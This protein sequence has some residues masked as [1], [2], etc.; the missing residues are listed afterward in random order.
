M[1]TFEK[2][3]IIGKNLEGN[4]SST[5]VHCPGCIRCL[6]QKHIKVDIK[7]ASYCVRCAAEYY[8]ALGVVY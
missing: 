4:I 3:K 6:T 7:G 1:L 5:W 2:G 8:D